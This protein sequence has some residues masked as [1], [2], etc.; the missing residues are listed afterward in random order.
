MRKNRNEL[1]GF[2]GSPAK[3]KNTTLAR[4]EDTRV[5]FW[6]QIL[7]ALQYRIARNLAVPGV[8]LFSGASSMMSDQTTKHQFTVG[9]F[10]IGLDAYWP[11]FEGLQERLQEYIQRVA[12]RLETTGGKV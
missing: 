9:L 10:G 7:N 6:M 1:E 12:A 4:R 2:I 11:Q 3:E 5:V 8:A